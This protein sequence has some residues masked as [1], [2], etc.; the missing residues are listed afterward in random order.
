MTLLD[1]ILQAYLQCSVLLLL[2]EDVHGHE[3]RPV[4]VSLTRGL[5]LLHVGD[6]APDDS[7][8]INKWSSVYIIID[9]AKAKA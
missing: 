4:N 1:R 2:G 8:T 7:C 9:V 6:G 5:Q 3:Q